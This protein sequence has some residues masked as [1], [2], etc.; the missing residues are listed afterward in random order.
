MMGVGRVGGAVDGALSACREHKPSA[1]F[2]NDAI[3]QPAFRRHKY[4]TVMVYKAPC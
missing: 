4:A 3:Q 2:Q 1:Q